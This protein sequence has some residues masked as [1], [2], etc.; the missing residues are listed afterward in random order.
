[1]LGNLKRC[2][3]VR[4]SKTSERKTGLPD[5]AAAV[6]ICGMPISVK[7][8]FSCPWYLK[9]ITH[10]NGL[11]SVLRSGWKLHQRRH[12][13]ELR[14]KPSFNYSDYWKDSYSLWQAPEKPESVLSKHTVFTSAGTWACCLWVIFHFFLHTTFAKRIP[15]V[16]VRLGCCN[17][18]HQTRN[19]HKWE[20][21]CSQFWRLRNSTLGC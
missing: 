19:L 7:N 20:S 10:F 17:K 13:T 5:K 16:S 3:S 14:H 21:Y 18:M 8:T 6:Q 2:Q 9:D 1:M 4:D 11:W 15:V 12:Y